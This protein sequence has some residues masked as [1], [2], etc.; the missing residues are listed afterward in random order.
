MLFILGFGGAVLFCPFAAII[1]LGIL[2]R[3]GRFAD[4][5][6]WERYFSLGV[7][8]FVFAAFLVVIIFK[9]KPIRIYEG[10]V[11]IQKVPFREGLAG[12]GVFVVAGEIAKVTY[13]TTKALIG[14]N[15]EYFRFHRLD[16]ENFDISVDDGDEERMTRLLR[17]VLRCEG[18]GAE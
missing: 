17:S 16:G 18:E 6:R 4:L 7:A 9:F 2:S 13:E 11:T 1:T 3:Q 8:F 14:G 12:R 10:C 5:D 15:I